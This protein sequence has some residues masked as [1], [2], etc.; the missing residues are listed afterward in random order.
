MTKSLQP[1]EDQRIVIEKSQ[2]PSCLSEAFIATEDSHFYN[3]IGLDHRQSSSFS[4]QFK[5][6]L[7]RRMA[8][9]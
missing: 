6:R 1:H 5:G 8:L 7:C 4:Y 2:M 3:H 9:P